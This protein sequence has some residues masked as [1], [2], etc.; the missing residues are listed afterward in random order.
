[1]RFFRTSFWLFASLHFGLGFW[2]C[3]APAAVTQIFDHKAQGIY[4]Q[5]Q[6]LLFFVI[7]SALAYV[8]EQPE[9]GVP[10]VVLLSLVK[11]LMSFFSW[12][13]LH[14]GELSYSHLAFELTLDF[15]SLPFLISYFFWFY[16]RPRPNRFVPY[17]GLFGQKK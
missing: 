1:M 16:H 8:A 2:F 5:S 7:A 12:V 11:L 10:V 13:G 9:H 3:L 4:L 15:L 14:H 6:G 17:I